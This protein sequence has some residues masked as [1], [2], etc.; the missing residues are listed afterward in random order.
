VIQGF[1]F[2]HPTKSTT[3]SF[4]TSDN[5]DSNKDGEYLIRILLRVLQRLHQ[6]MDKEKH[7]DNHKHLKDKVAVGQKPIFFNAEYMSPFHSL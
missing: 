4:I 2:L 5:D 7:E 6:R 3:L 1:T